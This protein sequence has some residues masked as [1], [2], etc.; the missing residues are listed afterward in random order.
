MF[1]CPRYASSFILQVI[2]S[3]PPAWSARGSELYGFTC[4]AE[5]P[6]L[7]TTYCR[8]R[9]SYVMAGVRVTV[10]TSTKAGTVKHSNRVCW[11]CGSLNV[12]ETKVVGVR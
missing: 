8:M 7:N 11:P 12:F 5:A 9:Y 3:P 10:C 4:R 1:V 6:S 2:T